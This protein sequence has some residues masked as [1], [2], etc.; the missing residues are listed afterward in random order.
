MIEFNEYD[1]DA[2]INVSLQVDTDGRVTVILDDWYDGPTGSQED[3]A[4]FDKYQDY[5]FENLD[6]YYVPT[7][8]W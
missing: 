4:I 7:F 2:Y 5:R 6:D 1:P 3:N 8:E